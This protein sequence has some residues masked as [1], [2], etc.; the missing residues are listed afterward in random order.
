MLLNSISN[1]QKFLDNLVEVLDI[2]PAQFRKAKDHYIAVGDWLAREESSLFEFSP[3]V[4]PQGSFRLGT[5]IKPITGDD[6]FDVDLVC[7]LDLDRSQI[8]QEEL[9]NIVGDRLKE[10]ADYKRMLK[11]EEGRRCWTLDYQASPKFHMDILPAIKDEFRWLLESRVSVNYA[12]SAI[13]ITDKDSEDYCKVCENW[14]KSN[15][16][17]YANWFRDQMK[18]QLLK[19]KRTLAESRR[20]AIQEIEEDEIK[21]PLQRAI[22]ILKRHRDIMFGDDEDRPISI[23]ITTLAARAYGEEDNIYLALR[24]ILDK[25]H[26]FIRKVDGI[27]IVENPI[28][29]FENFAD[30]WP[31]N[32]KKER[33]FLGWMKKAKEDIYEMIETNGFNRSIE[34]L[35]EVFGQRSV[36]EAL[37]R[38]GFVLHE[39]TL[40]N[41]FNHE[42]L[43]LVPFATHKE[44]PKWPISILGSVS[45]AARFEDEDGWHTVT[46]SSIISKGKYIWFIARTNVKKPFTVYW[47]VVNTGEEA[48]QAN[49]L[50][51]EIFQAKTAGVGGLKQKEHT[52]YTGTH[53]IECFIVKNGVCVARSEEFFVRVE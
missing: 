4:Y 30:K 37:N 2:T 25:M 15:P 11:E 18:V 14:N 32:G 45:I 9:K 28:N 39:R 7:E 33:N 31:K 3:Q 36:N 5:V 29:P 35:R 8:T 48:E 10:N 17:G 41:D 46:P 51:G 22:Q 47:Q 16:I 21:T 53:W 12:E 20:V 49:Q 42:K 19:R 13:C 24:N 34:N 38:S 1:Y 27:S 26:T 6:E 23:I 44:A 50:R 43:Q 40:T 52:G